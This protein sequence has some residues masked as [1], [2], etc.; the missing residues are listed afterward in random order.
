MHPTERSTLNV[1]QITVAHRPSWEK[2][3]ERL[4]TPN[5][6]EEQDYDSRSN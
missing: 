1:F 4:N 5:N 6:S 2:Y 3:Q